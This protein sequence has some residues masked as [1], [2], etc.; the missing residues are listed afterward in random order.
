MYHAEHIN[1]KEEAVTNT[2]SI[3]L[4]QHEHPCVF[5]FFALTG[6]SVNWFL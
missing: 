1:A 6:V 4:E 2:N 3:S 5:V